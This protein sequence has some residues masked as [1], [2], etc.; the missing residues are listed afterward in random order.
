MTWVTRVKERNGRDPEVTMTHRSKAEMLRYV[1]GNIRSEIDDEIET[2]DME[3]AEG[4][5]AGK[6]HTGAVEALRQAQEIDEALKR[7]NLEQAWELWQQY[8]KEWDTEVQIEAEQ[9]S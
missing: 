8:Q 3:I 5:D 7:D 4:R 6:V 9:T 2:W 1:A